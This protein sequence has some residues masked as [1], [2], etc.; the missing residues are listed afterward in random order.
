MLVMFFGTVIV[1]FLWGGLVGAT[2]GALVAGVLASLDADHQP[3]AGSRSQ[4]NK[5]MTMVNAPQPLQSRGLGA[6]PTRAHSGRLGCE[7]QGT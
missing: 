1:G 3:A 6:A 5:R 2:W 7:E 4:E